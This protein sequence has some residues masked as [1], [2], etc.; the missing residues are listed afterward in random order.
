MAKVYCIIVGNKVTGIC[1]TTAAGNQKMCSMPKAGEVMVTAV[2]NKHL[3]ILGS[4]SIWTALL[5]REVYFGKKK[6]CRPQTSLAS[7]SKAMWESVVNRV[8]RMLASR[9]LGS[10]FFSAR[11]NVG[12]N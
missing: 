10:N 7:W 3:T 9:P 1:T 12:G 4:C 11:A 8:V 5:F 2:P 6:M